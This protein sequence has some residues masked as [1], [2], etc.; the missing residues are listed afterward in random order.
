MR[1]VD[2]GDAE[3]DDVLAD[4]RRAGV[5]E[6]CADPGLRAVRAD[7]QI[8]RRT[9]AAGEVQ[10]AVA[11]GFERVPPAHHVL[12]EG[13]QQQVAQIGAVDLGSLKRCVVGRQSGQ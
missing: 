10:Q 1:A 2:V 13:I 6:Q 9:A 8:I 4:M 3:L 5:G 7:Q 12:G 11:G